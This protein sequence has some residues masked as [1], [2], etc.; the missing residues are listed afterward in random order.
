M[1][2]LSEHGNMEMAAF[3][4]LGK[5]GSRSK[6]NAILGKLSVNYIIYMLLKCLEI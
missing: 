3:K 4:L 6:F 5:R 2:K 1:E